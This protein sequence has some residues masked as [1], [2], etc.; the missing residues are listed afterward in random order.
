[1]MLGVG[2]VVKDVVEIVNFVVGIVV[3]KFGVVIV[4]FE[5]FSCKFG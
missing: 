3:S 5:E 4:L 2:M 1:M